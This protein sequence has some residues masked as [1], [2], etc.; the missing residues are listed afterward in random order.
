M[1]VRVVII[2]AF[3]F[4]SNQLFPW[5][6]FGHRKINRMAVFTLPPE[7]I[8]FYKKNIEFIAEHAVDPDKARN[9][10]KKEPPRH[11]IDS[12]HYISFDSI[13]LYWSD[14]VKKYSE[15]SLNEYGIVP[16]YIS[17]MSHKLTEA[18]KER[19]VNKILYISAH[20]GHYAADICVPLHTT[21]NYNGQLTGQK[22][23]HGLWESRLP[24]LFDQEYDYVVGRAEYLKNV[25]KEAWRMARISNSQVDS[26]LKIEKQIRVE[27]EADQTHSY[28]NKG[29]KPTKT[30]SK[31]YA[32]TYHQRL[33]GMVER[34]MQRAIKFVSSLWYTA[35]VDAGQPDLNKLMLQAETEKTKED[36]LEVPQNIKGHEE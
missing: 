26:V 13:P 19:D 32:T 6:F 12:E 14:A 5:G 36:S 3:L 24:E 23:I 22:G 18:F 33:N 29:N 15:D 30:F 34:N 11:Y 17:L 4:I 21:E 10:N 27:F 9:K 8:G 20:L 35:W 25:Q 7:M 1:K 2:F 16:W 31:A 28:E